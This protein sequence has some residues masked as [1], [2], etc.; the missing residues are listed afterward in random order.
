VETKQWL[1]SC[2][3]GLNFS[4]VRVAMGAAL[5]D[6]DPTTVLS[7]SKASQEALQTPVNNA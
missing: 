3:M 2:Y 6:L 1:F 7:G 4:L 5:G